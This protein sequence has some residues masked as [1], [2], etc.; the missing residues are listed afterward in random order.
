MP[1]RALQP[2]APLARALQPPDLGSIAT[3]AS[4]TPEITS[5]SPKNSRT[6]SR[7]RA[8]NLIPSAESL[9]LGETHSQVLGIRERASLGD[10]PPTEGSRGWLTG[11]SGS[12]TPLTSA[13][14][15]QRGRA[16]PTP[17]SGLALWA[18]HEL[19]LS[20]CLWGGS[21]NGLVI[22]EGPWPTALPAAGGGGKAF[23][24]EG[25]LGAQHSTPAGCFSCLLW[26]K[27]HLR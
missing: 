12:W 17:G 27:E 11:C 14:R 24:P 25:G 23:L 20:S 18:G 8:L 3:S 9:C 21:L 22:A 13:L 15:K 26:E 5:G 6:A 16:L 1:F 4:W 10:L 2:S 19:E 7:L